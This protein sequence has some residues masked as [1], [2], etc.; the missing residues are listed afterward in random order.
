ML[1]AILLLYARRI[2]PPKEKVCRPLNQLKVSFSTAVVSPRPC[3]SP[4]GPAKPSA[5][6]MLINGK[7]VAAGAPAGMVMPKAAGSSRA[8]GVK[9]R[10]S[11]ERRV[12][13]GGR[14]G[15]VEC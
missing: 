2:S 8:F 7:P 11:E 5:P 4:V 13:K 12:G 15:W 6:P 14:G 9:V 3:G 10:R 1:R